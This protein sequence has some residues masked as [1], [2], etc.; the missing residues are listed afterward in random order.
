MRAATFLDQRRHLSVEHRS[1]I[2][3]ALPDPPRDPQR[4]AARLSRRISRRTR[5]GRGAF[6]RIRISRASAKAQARIATALRQEEQ[7]FDRTLERGMAMLDRVSTKRSNARRRDRRRSG[8]H[9]ARYV[10]LS[11]R[12][13]ARDR[14]ASAARSST[15]SH[16]TG[17]WK[18]SANA[19]AATPRQS[20]R[21]ST[22]DRSAGGSQRVHRIRRGSRSGGPRRCDAQERR[23]RA[24]ADGWA[25]KARSSSTARRF[26]PSAADRSATA[27]R[28]FRRRSGARLRRARH[29]VYG[30]GDRAPRRRR[31][32]RDLRSA[33]RSHAASS[34]TGAA[35]FGA[36]TPRRICCSARSKTCSATKSIK[37][38][39]GSAS[40]ACVL[41]FAGPAAR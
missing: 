1:R 30:R 15:R 41:T 33:T 25:R 37:P 32:R 6:A 8:L 3:A 29:A 36:T 16:S 9:A 34:T 12:A 7:T 14:R 28:S 4:P 2:R 27:A 13:D 23:D 20:A 10:R 31:R 35:R 26:T 11:G 22:L 5:A 17:S 39:R 40:I 24:V 38:A 21:S 19:R 18:S